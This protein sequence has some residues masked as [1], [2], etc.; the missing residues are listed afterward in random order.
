M[1]RENNLI[2]DEDIQ[3]LEGW[4]DAIE[5]AVMIFLERNDPEEAFAEYRHIR[6]D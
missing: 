4:I 3:R 6:G 1:L 5:Y 2:A